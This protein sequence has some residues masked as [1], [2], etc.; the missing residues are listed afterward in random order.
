MEQ[1]INESPIKLT[2]EINN[3]I[4][5]IKN[6]L[7]NKY[8]GLIKDE[9][10]L[11]YFGNKEGLKSICE[12]YKIDYNDNNPNESMDKYSSYIYNEIISIVKDKNILNK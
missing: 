8:K 3:K 5:I 7:N 10:H 1:L 9:I 4:Q 2:N 6:L 11:R 12:L